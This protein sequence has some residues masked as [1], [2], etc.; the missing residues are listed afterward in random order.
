MPGVMI[1]PS[2][3]ARGSGELRLAHRRQAH[4]VGRGAIE[5]RHSREPR[6]GSRD[7]T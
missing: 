7:T 2:G 4:L 3:I 5:Q 1:V 6:A